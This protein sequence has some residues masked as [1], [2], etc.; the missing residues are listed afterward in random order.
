MRRAFAHKIRSPQKAL[1]AGS[2][3]RGF[4]AETPVGVAAVVKA[5]AELVTK[6]AQ[7]Q[8]RRLRNS[9]HVPAAGDGV[10]EGLQPSLG[11]E[12]GTIGGGEYHTRSADGRAHRAGCDD[13][14]AHCACRLIARSGNH[15][16]S[17]TQTAG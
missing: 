9:H 2:N 13:S 16:G 8:A 7:R 12:R 6:P 14:H 3:S 11:F 5:S 15:G 1:T 10:A 17:L 4:V